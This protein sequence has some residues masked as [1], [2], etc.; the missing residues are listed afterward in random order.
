MACNLH[1]SG[2]FYKS[3]VTLS[4]T[5]DA[6]NF[7]ANICKSQSPNITRT[8]Q[9]IHTHYGFCIFSLRLLYIYLKKPLIQTKM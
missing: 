4:S 2:I 3:N 5:E 7:F 8:Q 6:K 9:G 1:G